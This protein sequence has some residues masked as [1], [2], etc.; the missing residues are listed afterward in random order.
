MTTSTNTVANLCPCPSCNTEISRR[1][2]FCPKRAH[3]LKS[4]GGL[5]LKDPV[6]LLGI[7]AMLV[8]AGLVIVIS[9]GS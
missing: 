9:V 3:R 5:R 7:P 4:A 1:A 6:H 8:I 2:A